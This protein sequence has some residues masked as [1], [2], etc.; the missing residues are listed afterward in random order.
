MRKDECAMRA[1]T[2]LLLL[3]TAVALA[4]ANS[5]GLDYT[6]STS[7]VC[8]VPLGCKLLNSTQEPCACLKCAKGWQ[9]TDD[10][11]CGE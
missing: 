9:T 6:L 10:G 2:L 7:E 4:A 11:H 1:L 3:A 5:D 8:A